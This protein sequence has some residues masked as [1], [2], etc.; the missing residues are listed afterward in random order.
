MSVKYQIANFN[1]EY[2]NGS[3]RTLQTHEMIV[4]IYLKGFYAQKGFLEEHILF[5]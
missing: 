2:F 1:Q 5:V 3:I 4:F